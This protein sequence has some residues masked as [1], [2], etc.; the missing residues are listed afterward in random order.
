MNNIL[1]RL[2]F[3]ALTLLLTLTLYAGP[4]EI[5][6][7]GVVVGY[8]NSKNPGRVHTYYAENTNSEDVTLIFV[9][10]YPPGNTRTPIK[11]DK[12]SKISFDLT[13]NALEIQRI[14]EKS[15]VE[16]FRSSSPLTN[17]DKPQVSKDNVKEDKAREKA[18]EPKESKKNS[19]NTNNAVVDTK[20]NTAPKEIVTIPVTTDT[21]VTVKKL[22]KKVINAFCKYLEEK[23]SY[24]S[25]SAMTSDS[26]NVQDHIDNL[27]NSIDRGKY[28]Q[29]KEL[30]KLVE[31]MKD[32]LASYQHDDS[33]LIA[34]FFKEYRTVRNSDKPLY[35]D[36]LKTI[37][38]GRLE[39]REQ[40]LKN[41]QQAM[42]EESVLETEPK[43]SEIDW[44]M[45][46]V[47][48]VMLLLLIALIVWYRNVRR[49]QKTA[50]PGHTFRVSSDTGEA[51]GIVVRNTTST[52]LKKQNLDDVI[53]NNDYLRISCSEFCADSAVRYMYL[54][55]T[56]IRDI[57]NLYAED[58]R[59]PENPK[60]DGCMVLGRWVH[61]VKTG[62]YDVSLEQI[63]LPG[64]DAVFAEYEL[65]F[66]GKIQMKRSEQLR[67][68]RRETNLQY[69]LTCWVHSHPGLGVFFS[70]SDNNVHM[71]LKHPMHPNFLT[72]IVV[73]ILTPDQEFGIFTFRSDSTLNSK[74]DLIRM[75]SLEVMYKWA[76]GSLRTSFK[77]EDHFNTLAQVKAPIAEC[78]AIHLSNGAI[79]D[80]GLLAAES[81]S[82]QVA[83]AHGFL[84]QY[85]DKA[86]YVV[87]KVDKSEVVPD[88]EV[89]GCFVVAAHCSIP[90]IRK[91]IAPYLNQVHFVLVYTA[92]DD[93]LTSIP[94]IDRDLSN[95][96]DTYGEQK[97]EDL[98]IWTRRKR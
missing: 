17:A 14:G 4:K 33:T 37:L 15:A 85:D 67:K 35:A 19:A 58:L 20:E 87:A 36:S 53:D 56:C 7:N 98:K 84:Q 59:N 70:N 27:K 95:N 2:F 25:M 47:C 24:Y 44:K 92:S 54:K 96:E 43:A 72:A 21:I 75:Y 90:S 51:A 41:L 49:R 57:Y 50:T 79:I 81:A 55:N 76:V 78:Q 31:Q 77:P 52:V 8:A 10:E 6:K 94:V 86:V 60:E 9:N 91:T 97:L 74:S 1:R 66:G 82:G 45:V 69:D 34:A 18:N 28:I 64:N 80:M 40:Y 88:N 62:Q 23:A 13:F 61:D 89:I 16:I 93:V 83:L 22:D 26:M 39:L 65:N 68:L 11:L 63:V 42:E 30:D 3:T 32:S 38:K 5:R 71:Q 46:G 12:K 48:A 29:S 73:D